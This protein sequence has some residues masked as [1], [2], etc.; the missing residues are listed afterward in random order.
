MLSRMSIRDRLPAG[1]PDVSAKIAAAARF[2][3]VPF[4]FDIQIPL[5]SSTDIGYVP[6]RPKMAAFAMQM[7]SSWRKSQK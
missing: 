3:R 1:T 2:T 4:C 6:E 5:G 7:F